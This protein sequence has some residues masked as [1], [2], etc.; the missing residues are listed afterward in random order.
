MV[1][2]IDIKGS[3][4]SSDSQW[5][6]DLMELEA[7]SPRKVLATL[8][9]AKGEPVEVYVNSPGGEV[10]SGSEIYTALKEYPGKVTVSIVGIAASAASVI[11]MAGD[12][13][14]MSPTSQ[15]MI[16]NI[17][18]RAS[19]DYRTMDH[20]AKMLANSNHTVANAYRIK[21]GIDQ[22]I[23]LAMMDEESWMTAAQAKAYGFIDEVMF[24]T[25]KEEA[26]EK[27]K[28]LKARGR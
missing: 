19:G 13:V 8:D 3:I 23:L 1:H 14:R 4:I 15:M 17:S 21:T 5:V 18:S 24:M 11:A 7:T 25:P 20:A 6:Y 28:E 16:H 9:K 2:R 22:E 26:V 10:F 27:L 12:V